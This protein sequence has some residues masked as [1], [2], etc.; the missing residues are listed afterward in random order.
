MKLVYLIEDSG[1]KNVY[2]I[3][4]TKSESAEKRLKTLNCGNP[5]KL[6]LRSVYYTDTPSKLEARL[7]RRFADFRLEGEWFNLNEYA[8]NGF[9]RWCE[10]EQ[11]IIDSLSENP[12]Y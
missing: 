11:N 10:F 2:K 7:H 5:S 6:I 3:G 4:Y 1:R 8:V 12:F 9:E